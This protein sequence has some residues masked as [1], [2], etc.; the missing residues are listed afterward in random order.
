MAPPME[1]VP[2]DI[3]GATLILTAK[4]NRYCQTEECVTEFAR[5]RAWE[6]TEMDG[7]CEIWLQRRVEAHFPSQ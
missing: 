6:R 4:A 3:C 5:R 1:E 2:C 7:D